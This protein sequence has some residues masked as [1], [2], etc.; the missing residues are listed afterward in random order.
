VPFA[1]CKKEEAPKKAVQAPLVA[2]TGDD[3]S[4][5]RAYV[6]DAVTRNMGG[7]SNQPFVYLLPGESSEDFEGSYERLAEKAET[8]VARGIIA[9]NM[10]AY[11]G[12]SSAKTADLVIAAFTGVQPGTM[13][14]VKV[15]FIGTPADSERVKAA[16]EPAGVTYVFV[17]A[18]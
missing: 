17:E 5:W 12:P 11:G 16:V 14:G 3:I 18:K 1:A 10:L 9:G 15:L 6:S 8:D 13:K 4:A 2:P 7:I